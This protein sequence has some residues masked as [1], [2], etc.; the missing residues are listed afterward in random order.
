MRSPPCR[1]ALLVLAEVFAV[2][3]VALW[4][5][6]RSVNPERNPDSGGRNR[7]FGN[8]GMVTYLVVEHQQRVDVLL[9]TW[10]GLS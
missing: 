3:E 1:E 2:L 6:G 7:P 4:R 8:A 10:A 9:V 5:A